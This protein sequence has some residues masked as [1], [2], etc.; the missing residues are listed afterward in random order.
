MVNPMQMLAMLQQSNN[1][2]G[3]LNV[4]AGSNPLLQRAMQMAQGKSPEQMRVIAQN[5]ASQR[6]MSPEQFNQYLHQFG[7]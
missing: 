3:M 7:L 6:G 2:M 1:P 4:M 5:L